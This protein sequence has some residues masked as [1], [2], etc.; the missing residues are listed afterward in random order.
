MKEMSKALVLF[1]KSVHSVLNELK[2]LTVFHHPFL[3]NV[4]VAFQDHANLYLVLDF[5]EG[6]DLR[7]HLGRKRRFT[8]AQTSTAS[9]N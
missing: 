7:Y 6:G 5:L 3:V 1:K 4:H 2:L 9:P 8:E